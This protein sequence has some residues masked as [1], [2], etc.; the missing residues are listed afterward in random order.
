LLKKC[1]NLAKRVQLEPGWKNENRNE[2]MVEISRE[3]W[4]LS[5]SDFSFLD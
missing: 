1:S 4:I 3:H 5:P 2:E